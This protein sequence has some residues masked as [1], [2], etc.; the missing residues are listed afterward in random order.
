MSLPFTRA[1]FFD[2]F[3]AY[4]ASLWPF[5]IA[6]WLLTVGA[7]VIVVRGNR[8]AA[9][10]VS[11]LLAIH[12][13]WAAV[14]Y[15]AA[16]FSKIN[17]AAW[18][19]SALFLVQAGLFVWFGVLRAFL[20][21]S[22]GQSFRSYVAWALVGYSLLYPALVWAAG[23]VYPRLPTFG[24]PCP[25]TILTIGFL[26][27]ADRPVP[28]VLA[29]IPILWALIGGSAAF[30]LGVPADVVMLAAGIWLAATVVRLWYSRWGVT[31]V[32]L[33][34]PM[35]G[36][37]EVPNPTYRAMVAVTV[38][39]PPEYIWPWLL[40]MGKGRGGLYSYDWLDRL[41]GYLDAPSA[42]RILPQFQHLAPG[43]VIPVGGATGGFPVKAVQPCEALVL[44]GGT[45]A[46]RWIWQL[47]LI[48]LSRSRTR[49]ISRSQARV[50]WTAGSFLFML[51][52]EPAAF[53]MTRRM[54]L[55]IKRRAEALCRRGE[56]EAL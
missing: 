10:L 5:A 1:Q 49:L 20:R 34:R 37:N 52:L 14:A 19:F 51:A 56:M 12:W 55:G 11:L 4:N 15:H 2:V 39:T 36:D 47:A 38:D 41:F 46:F 6:L 30:L 40:Q 17:P 7:V 24:V 26:L 16:F 53:I 31:D 33:N 50:P 3:A 54:L 9:R 25:T 35:P 43:D 13:G 29:V 44:G 48:P 45:D 23:N 18:L 8:G 42:E 32:E 21:Y 27:A 22:P 28:G